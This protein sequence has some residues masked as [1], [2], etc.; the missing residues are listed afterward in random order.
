[1]KQQR[2]FSF[3]KNFLPYYKQLHP[4]TKSALSS[5]LAARLQLYF[6]SG[7]FMNGFF[8]FLE[9]C[10]HASY[11]KGKSWTEELGFSA[12]E[13]NTAFENI[14][15]TYY[16][17]K[18][19]DAAK[20]TEGGLFEKLV[21]VPRYDV[22][23]SKNSDNETVV[24]RKKVSSDQVLKTM[25]FCRYVDKKTNLTWYFKNYDRDILHDALSIMSATERERRSVANEN[26]IT[27]DTQNEKG[28]LDG[29]RKAIRRERE[30]R[31]PHL[32]VD[33]KDEKE[34]IEPACAGT[35]NSLEPQTQKQ[36]KPNV[37][38][39]PTESNGGCATPAEKRSEA[40]PPTDGLRADSERPAADVDFAGVGE[41]FPSWKR[42]VMSY[43][44]TRDGHE[45]EKHLK[46]A[47]KGKDLTGEKV[48][49]W[50]ARCGTLQE[51]LR[52]NVDGT[53][54]GKTNG[55]SYSNG[56]SNGHANGNGRAAPQFKPVAAPAPTIDEKTLALMLIIAQ[57]TFKNLTIKQHSE[58]CQAVAVELAKVGATCEIITAKFGANSWWYQ[59]D[60]RGQ[61]GSCPTPAQLIEVWGQW[62]NT[63]GA[64]GANGTTRSTSRNGFIP[65]RPCQWTG[66]NGGGASKPVRTSKRTYDV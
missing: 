19:Y 41:D 12:K 15:V 62:E 34:E 56:H 64:N 28:V 18:E 8:K 27:D 38:P 23:V 60:W 26:P 39:L 45:I 7:G 36:E 4:I 5:I 11:R 21:D 32:D 44:G 29:T 59:K 42:Y 31:S 46:K 22:E 54:S 63:N 24:K 10:N 16:S 55:R 40:G 61:K 48:V 51:W 2:V 6:E 9:P 35:A 33:L 52:S 1:M 57:V 50:C 14:G 43:Y 20:E 30:T 49:A 47:D 53:F 3:F 65:G 58:L 13:F 37:E 66:D 25:Y 17:K